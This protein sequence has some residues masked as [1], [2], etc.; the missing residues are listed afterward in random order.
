MLLSVQT[1]KS[2]FLFFLHATFI[3][4]NFIMI[5][6]FD[7]LILLIINVVCSLL[8]SE[9]RAKLGLKPLGIEYDSTQHT[10][11]DVKLTGSTTTHSPVIIL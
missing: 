9:K 11:P 5:K 2:L 4:R 3:D 8:N 1:V 7:L 6:R 10:E